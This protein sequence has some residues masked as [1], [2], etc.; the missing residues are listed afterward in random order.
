MPAAVT[1]TATPFPSQDECHTIHEALCELFGSSAKVT[2]KE[3]LLALHMVLL[4]HRDVLLVSPTGSGK[5][6]L[7]LVAALLDQRHLPARTSVLI[8]PYRALQQQ[9]CNQ[10]Q[11]HS[12]NFAV[13]PDTTPCTVLVLSVEDVHDTTLTGH[14]RFLHDQDLLARVVWD[15]VHVLFDDADYRP[16]VTAVPDLRAAL[17]V[18]F[19]MMSA[20]VPLQRQA[21][22][23][24]R[25]ASNPVVFRLPSTRPNAKVPSSIAV[26][27]RSLLCRSGVCL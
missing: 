5:S 8:A 2:S 13:W 14:L 7:Y 9:Y 12:I 25:L 26:Y 21:W 19:V 6:A 24:E 10:L 4:A 17:A 15:E 11:H 23:L 20:T 1:V 16:K 27:F 3:Q 22:L 18:P